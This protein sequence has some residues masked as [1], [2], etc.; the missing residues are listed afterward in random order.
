MFYLLHG[1][2]KDAARAKS[3]EMLAAMLAKKPNAA[4]FR[5]DGDNFTDARLEELIGSA[6]L[7]EKK[8]IVIAD[9]L[10]EKKETGQALL[11]RAD[12]IAGSENVFLIVDGKIDAKSMKK[13]EKHAAKVQE[14]A[15]E[16]RGGTSGAFGAAAGTSGKGPSVFAMADAFGARDR[17]NLWAL[18]QKFA[19]QGSVPEEI[20]GMLF[21]QL[22]AIILAK[23]PKADAKSAGLNPFVFS[24]A[25]QFAKNYTEAELR[26]LSSQLVRMYHEAHRGMGDFGVMLER[27]VLQV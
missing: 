11:D 24:K 22:K 13:L 25:R 15:A 18:Y 9:S 12:E 3:Q 5:L 21:W 4:S 26:A 27:F 23:D 14:F 19:L 10:F 8:Y 16:K 2:N 20:S 17:K 6:S 7:F 1:E